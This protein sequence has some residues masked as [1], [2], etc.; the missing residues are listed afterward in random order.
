VQ[1]HGDHD[2]PEPSGDESDLVEG[3]VVEEA[4]LILKDGRAFYA[5]VELAG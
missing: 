4:I 5:K 1:D 3:T 2:W